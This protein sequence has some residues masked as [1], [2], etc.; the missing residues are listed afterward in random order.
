MEMSERN[1]NELNHK[2]N[3]IFTYGTLKRG[4]PNHSLMESLI[5]TDDAVYLGTYR[6][7]HEHPLVCGP[8]GVPFLL[9]LPGSGGH[10]ILGELYAVSD[11]GLVPV[12]ELEGTKIGHYERLPIQV[13][14][15]DDGGQV[16][17]VE[18]YFAHRSFAEAMWR[19]QGRLG[20]GSY[21]E[22]E[23]KAYVRRDF[24]PKCRTFLEDIQLFVSSSS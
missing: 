16:V 8:H 7:V 11:G 24:R 17:E 18:A 6:T 15:A 22:E 4:F 1:Q 10:R 19:R 3:L 5:G 14:D 12:D 20:F 9:N 2:P 21:T 23:A 13:V